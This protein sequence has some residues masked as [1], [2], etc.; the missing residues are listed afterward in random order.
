MD[1]EAINEENSALDTPVFGDE[2]EPEEFVDHEAINEENSALDTPV[3]GDEAEPEEFVDHEVINEENSAPDTPV[4]GDEFALDDMEP[5]TDE[6]KA[7]FT[8]PE[9]C[10]ELNA[11]PDEIEAETK[12][13]VRVLAEVPISPV[14]VEHQL[15]DES[16]EETPM[17]VE[18]DPTENNPIEAATLFSAVSMFNK[19]LSLLQQRAQEAANEATDRYQEAC[20]SVAQKAKELS[21]P[22]TEK[23]SCVSLNDAAAASKEPLLDTESRTF[24]SAVSVNFTTFQKRAQDAATEASG[25]YHEAY[26]TVAQRAQVASQKAHAAST[27]VAER[28]Q[29]AS[30]SVAQKAHEASGKIATEASKTKER[31]NSWSAQAAS[32]FGKTFSKTDSTASNDKDEAPIRPTNFSSAFRRGDKGDEK[33]EE[34][35]G[36]KWK[37]ETPM[38]RIKNLGL[39]FQRPV[40]ATKSK[41]CPGEPSTTISKKTNSQ[42]ESPDLKAQAKPNFT[43]WFRQNF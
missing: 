36:K 4:F 43:S 19:K 25:R 21:S 42:V 10:D 12:D 28:A 32:M 2:A 20:T 7:E 14:P 41:S 30:A 22:S 29:K 34:S 26:S 5:E 6:I 33:E 23:K 38:L 3:F 37:I 31:T 8:V 39:A 13:A 1:H 15:M 18:S 24:F 17:T 27:I 35:S 9:E 16:D 40:A 11:T